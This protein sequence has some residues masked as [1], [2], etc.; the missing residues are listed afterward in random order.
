MSILRKAMAA[1]E[2]SSGR[3][4]VV[5][6]PGASDENLQANIRSGEARLTKAIEELRASIA[7]VTHHRAAY[8]KHLT[9]L[10]LGIEVYPQELKR[11]DLELAIFGATE[12]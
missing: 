1:V 7:D 4:K 5:E 3:Q 2:P 12:A 6:F 8:A 11:Q 10:D 9:A